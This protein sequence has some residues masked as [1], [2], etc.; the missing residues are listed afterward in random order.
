CCDEGTLGWER[1][2]T[3]SYSAAEKYNTTFD[4]YQTV[5][6]LT[7]GRYLLSCQGFYRCGSYSSAASARTADAEA[8]NAKLYAHSNLCDVDTSLVSIFSEAGNVG[9]VGVS[10][11]PYGYIPNTM[12]QASFYFLAGLYPN[13]L[14]CAVGSDGELTIGV[15]KIVSVSTDWTIFDTFSLTYLGE[16]DEQT[17]ISGLSATDPFHRGGVYTLSGMRVASDVSLAPGIYIIDGKK[18]VR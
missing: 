5:T 9:T 14:E 7:P 13:Q 10:Q 3:V 16:N 11:S 17:G 12:E 8:L 18:V 15:K 6:G 1:S 2:P 4:V